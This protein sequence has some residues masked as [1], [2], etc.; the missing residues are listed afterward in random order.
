[1]GSDLKGVSG[2]PGVRSDS[3]F[4]LVSFYVPRGEERRP[5]YICTRQ[6]SNS[7]QINIIG[8]SGHARLAAYSCTFIKD[9]SFFKRIITNYLELMF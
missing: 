7:S 2:V 1:M 4:K 3:A 9:F 6:R 5:F 8:L